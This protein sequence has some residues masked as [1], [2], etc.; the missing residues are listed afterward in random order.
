V[1]VPPDKHKRQQHKDERDEA[2][3]TAKHFGGAGDP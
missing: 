1:Q 3:G 2:R